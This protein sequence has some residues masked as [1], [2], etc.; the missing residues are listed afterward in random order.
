M[1]VDLEAE[2]WCKRAYLRYELATHVETNTWL[3]GLTS[4]DHLEKAREYLENALTLKP[5]W[6]PAQVYMAL[7]LQIMG[8]VDGADSYFQSLRGVDRPAVTVGPSMAAD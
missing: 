1:R 6:N 2:L 7:V 3:P 4:K 5:H 8:D